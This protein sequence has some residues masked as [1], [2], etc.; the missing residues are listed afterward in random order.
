VF[1][2]NRVVKKIPV[3]DTV[4]WLSALGKGALGK[5]VAR[6]LR[7]LILPNTPYIQDFLLTSRQIVTPL[8][9]LPFYEAPVNSY[10]GAQTALELPWPG[11]SRGMS[12]LTE[13]ACTLPVL[14]E[15]VHRTSCRSSEPCSADSSV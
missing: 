2:P 8:D 4:L 9:A 11:V 15:V 5:R 1:A 7:P 10:D 14:P 3:S 6:G 13:A 12:S